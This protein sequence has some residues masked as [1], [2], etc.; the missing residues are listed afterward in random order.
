MELFNDYLW[1]ALYILKALYD[2][3]KGEKLVNRYRDREVDG[4]DMYEIAM[5]AIGYV[6]ADTRFYYDEEKEIDVNVFFDPMITEFFRLC[7]QYEAEDG[8]PPE[9]DPYRQELY[10]AIDTGFSFNSYS[11]IYRVYTDT[12]KKNGCRIVL[13][14]YC[15]FCTHYEVPG[16]LLDVYDAFEEQTLRLKREL[17]MVKPCEVLTMPALHTEEQEAA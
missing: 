17:G 8:V 2:H 10:Q 14:F 12:S 16:G 7:E 9:N 4:D 3:G 1:E 15:E 6:F 5:E 13:L 11:Y